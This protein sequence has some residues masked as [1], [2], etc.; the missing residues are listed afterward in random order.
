VPLLLYIALLFV[1]AV[2][3]AVLAIGG[4]GQSAGARAI[5]GIAAAA[6]LGYAVYLLFFFEGGKYTVFLYAFVVPVIAVV[7]MVKSR[8]AK[9]AQ[10]QALA[11][12]DFNQPQGGAFGQPYQ[13][14]HPDAFAQPGQPPAADEPGRPAGTHPSQPA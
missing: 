1:S 8:K 2:L 9:R 12:A 14:P 3:L 4:F 11:Q 5:D 13:P 6:F 7:Q 10:Q